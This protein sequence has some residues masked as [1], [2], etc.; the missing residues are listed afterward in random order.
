MMVNVV[1]VGNAGMVRLKT[2]HI[3]NIN[4]GVVMKQLKSIQVC[5]TAHFE[6]LILGESGRFM[7]IWSRT[8]KGLRFFNCR[9]GVHHGKTLKVSPMEDLRLPYIIVWDLT[10]K[11]YRTI[12]L[13]TILTIRCS[14]TLYLEPELAEWLRDNG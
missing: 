11:G 12:N 1:I 4:I 10:K 3:L 9:T 14:K 13:N 2:Y 5:N 8:K 6:S 7:G